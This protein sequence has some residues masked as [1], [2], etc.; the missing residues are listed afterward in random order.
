MNATYQL[1]YSGE[2]LP[3]HDPQLVRSQ[4]S[5]T[6]KITP[7]QAEALFSGRRVVLR[8]GLPEAE[9]ARYVRH[10]EA[11]GARVHAELLPVSLVVPAVAAPASQ[12]ST[13]PELARAEP[14]EEI[15]CPKCSERQPK[16]TLCRACAVDMKRFAEA[17][18]EAERE[19]REARLAARRGETHAGEGAVAH[20]A[21]GA[22]TAGV[23]GL[24]F[25]GRI[26]RLDYLFGGLLCFAVFLLGLAALV[27]GENI[28]LF[29]LASVVCGFSSLR[30]A[31]LRCHDQGWSG[32]MSLVMLV[33]YLGWLFGLLLMVL[34]G[35]RSDNRFGVPKHPLPVPAMLAM[36]V[37]F[38]LSAAMVARSPGG[39]EKLQAMADGA[40]TA[41][42]GERIGKASSAESM[43]TT[44]QVEIFTTTTCGECAR[45]KSYMKQQRIQYVERDV[46]F[47]IET[48]KE[49]YDRGG[50][51]VPFIFVRGQS[52]HGFNE[53]AFERLLAG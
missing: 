27:R 18:A 51:G 1:T 17:K 4:V 33:P 19:E 15:V 30:L 31:A 38:G 20:A 8:K 29:L 35:E 39:F 5:A 46:E 3:G 2:I 11:M 45:A 23:V 42:A 13:P 43:A 32:W 44:A 52:M 22:E 36:V 9:V 7:E 53:G 6:L 25:S 14:V 49:F 12:V 48:R 24:G 26:G 21:F 34:P 37:V 16:R 47:D 40:Q 10:F 41:T 50:R 28:A